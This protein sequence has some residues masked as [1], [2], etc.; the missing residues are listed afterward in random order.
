MSANMITLSGP[1]E[2][3]EASIE[4]CTSELRETST[5][6]HD[7][8][9]DHTESVVSEISSDDTVVPGSELADDTDLAAF[10]QFIKKTA[11]RV[12]VCRSQRAR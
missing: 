1:Y 9:S 4:A 8:C 10:Q 7:A 12:L 5:Q 11:Y 6:L 2:G 3:I